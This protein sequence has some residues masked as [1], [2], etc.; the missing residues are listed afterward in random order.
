MDPEAGRWL[1]AGLVGRPHGL[2]GSFYVR[3]PTPSLLDLGANV[4]IS[5]RPWTIARRAGDERRPIIRL[6]GCEDRDA[7]QA[8]RG[9]ALMVA[10]PEAPPLGDDEW[11]EADLVGCVV[12]DGERLVGTVRRLLGMPSVDVLEVAVTDGGS[13]LLVPLVR[14]AVRSVDTERK[15]IDVDLR[16]LGAD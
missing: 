8:L 3:E 1:R 9:E 4:L 6:E 14:D 15:L 11:W 7:V 16:F 2:D 13:D 12:R 5:G 10:R